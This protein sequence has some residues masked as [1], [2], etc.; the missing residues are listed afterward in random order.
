[1]EFGG[2][3]LFSHGTNHSRGV[4]VAISSSLNLRAY[5]KQSGSGAARRG[6]LGRNFRK[7]SQN[8]L[9]GSVVFFFPKS[10]SLKSGRGAAR[11]AG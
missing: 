6:A 2:T 9:Y 10:Q 7:F 3:V 1:M 4:L 8:F 11:C 5:S